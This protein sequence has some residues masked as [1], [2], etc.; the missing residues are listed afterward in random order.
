MKQLY[1]I[2]T[3]LL[4]FCSCQNKNRSNESLFQAENISTE[5]L[6]TITVEVEDYDFEYLG[7]YLKAAS[8]VQL[9]AEPLIG[10]IKEVQIKNEKK[11]EL[12]AFSRNVCY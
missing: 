3:F 4:I 2:T 1:Y 12:D 10:D 9:A 5:G 11:Y 7:K 8:Y 6:Q